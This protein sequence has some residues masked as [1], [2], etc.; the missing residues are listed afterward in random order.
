[1][2]ARSQT[3]RHRLLAR[4]VDGGCKLWSRNASDFTDQF[5][6]I[7]AAAAGLP[8][9][10]ATL[11]GEA[12]VL[13]QD[14]PSDFGALRSRE[15]GASAILIAFDLLELDGGDLRGFPLEARRA[16][17]AVRLAQAGKALQ[18]S[19]GFTHEGGLV[20][21]HACRLSLEGIISKRL[22]TKYQTGRCTNWLKTKNAA[23]VRR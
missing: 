14:G 21:G 22:G 7:A 5:T 3:R 10:S 20:F 11:D 13:R 6:S 19:E 17:L 12:V 18:F 4:V 23:F 2:A 8:V 16:R 1:L 9:R 15:G